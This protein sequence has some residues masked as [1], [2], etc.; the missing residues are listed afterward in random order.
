M[1]PDL[2]RSNPV[3]RGALLGTLLAIAYGVA[4]F[5]SSGGFV[6]A[7]DHTPRLFFDFV[8]Y[9]YASAE[10]LREGRGAA[11]GYL[12]SPVLA[13][14]LIPLTSLGLELAMVAW[15]AVQALALALLV[16][17]TAAL[18]PPGVLGG[19]LAALLTLLSTATLHSLKWGQ[20]GLILGV[21]ILEGVIALARRRDLTAA[22]LLG[23]AIAIKFYPAIVWPLTAVLRRR[24]AAV[25][26]FAVSAALLVLPPL[27]V[28]DILEPIRGAA[29]FA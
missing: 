1:G 14:A 16:L 23:S 7:I 26:A 28:D 6:A 9:Y 4:R 19:F 11:S 18:G 21:L 17:R 12:Y 25:G 2:P 15:A 22:V 10:S 5:G 20:V 3:Q 27:L 29:R 13:I 8:H 24:R